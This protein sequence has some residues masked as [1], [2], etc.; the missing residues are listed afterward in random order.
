MLCKF[1]FFSG[2]SLSNI[3]F[4]CVL[5]LILKL[6]FCDLRIWNQGQTKIILACPCLKCILWLLKSLFSLDSS[7]LSIAETAG[8]RY[9]RKCRFPLIRT[10]WRRWT[11]RPWWSWAAT[12]TGRRALRA[13]TSSTL[14]LE[15]G[16]RDLPWMLA[17]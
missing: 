3:L 8:N 9:L 1:Y 5:F 17:G 13:L 11:R 15:L 2:S 4:C 14:W 7:D 10:A 16:W 6:H 12:R